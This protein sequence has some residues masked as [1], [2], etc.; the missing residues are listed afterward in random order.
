VNL[1]QPVTI[2]AN[3]TYVASYQTNGEYVA[4]TNFFTNALTSGQL[5]APSSASVSGGNGVY[6]FGGSNAAGVFPTNTFNAANYYADV[7]FRPGQESTPFTGKI[8]VC[9]CCL[10]AMTDRAW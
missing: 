8:G 4:T 7:V 6:A 10:T 1:A 5:T 2:S 9:Y 3:T